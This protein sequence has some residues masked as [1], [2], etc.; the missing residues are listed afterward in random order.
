MRSA[1]PSA[2]VTPRR[3]P[4]W[5]CRG[6]SPAARTAYLRSRRALSR[7]LPRHSA[8]SHSWRPLRILPVQVSR[9]AA[10]RAAP[11]ARS[12]AFHRPSAKEGSAVNPSA[13]TVP[14]TNFGHAAAA[15]IAALS[16]DSASDGNA[17]GKC[18]ARASA[19]NRVRSSRF[20]ATPSR[21]KIIRPKHLCR[22]KRLPPQI[23]HHR[24]LKRRNQIQRPLI[25][26]RQRAVCGFAFSI[27]ASAVRRASIASPIACTCV[28]RS[29]AVLI[30]LNE[31]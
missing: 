14:A 24:P 28:W 30:P 4:T 9:P 21:D 8:S 23:I 7:A 1:L 12:Q 16:V 2:G 27:A 17:I 3:A 6:A 15:I 29:I 22:A 11:D 20:A 19:V 31:K 18:R 10:L 26:Q 25:H 13:A 5:C